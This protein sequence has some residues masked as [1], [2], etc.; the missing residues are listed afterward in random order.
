MHLFYFLTC[1]KALVVG[2]GSIGKRHIENLS[3]YPNIEILVCT[4]RRMDQFL[5]KKKCRI[6][7]NITSSLKEE[8]DVAFVTN[9]SNL[10]V[11][12]ATK[13]ARK[14]IDMFIEK[15][16]SNSSKGVKTLLKIVKKRKLITLMGFPLRFHPCLIKIKEI[17]S[18][19]ELG[20]IIFVSAENGSYLPDWHPNENYIE[21]YAA[22]ED[23]GGGAVLTCIHELDYLF[24]FLGNV[25]DIFSVTGKYS[26]LD[27]QTDDLSSI[28]LKFKN[29]TIGEVHLDFFQ[30]PAFRNCKIVGT[31]GTIYWN[32]DENIVRFYDLKKKRWINK[33][34]LNKFDINDMYISELDHFLRCVKK[35]EKTLNDIEQ[36]TKVLEIALAV[37]KAS[38]VKRMI[39]VS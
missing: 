32:F 19:K 37:K 26:T 8:P 38:K 22:R 9:V 28:L 39:R 1:L 12:T 29:K 4:N 13:L 27:I 20:K 25:S 35:R 11:S 34:K 10:H 31:N 6:F 23:L 16:L 21:S 2:Y 3:H 18:K 36:G 17:I 15:P 30:R 7:N 33:L 5:R 24:W 14:N